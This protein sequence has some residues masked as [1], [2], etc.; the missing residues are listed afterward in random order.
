ME[1]FIQDRDMKKDSEYSEVRNLLHPITGSFV[2]VDQ[3]NYALDKLKDLL[4][5][6]TVTIT[7]L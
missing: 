6:N 4:G 7:S 2:K 5:Q 1:S 3:L